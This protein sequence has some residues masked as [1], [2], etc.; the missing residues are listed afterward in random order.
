MEV[1]LNINIMKKQIITI[2]IIFICSPSLFATEDTLQINKKIENLEETQEKLE[3]ELKLF[4]EQLKQFDSKKTSLESSVNAIFQ[5]SNRL[6]S[7]IDSLSSLHA[8][9]KHSID[10]LDAQMEKQ[11][12]EL[13]G[14]ISETRETTTASIQEIDESLSKNTLYWII[15]I[16]FVGLLSLLAFIFLRKKTNAV[17]VSLTENIK[18]TRNE[19]EVEAVKLDNKLIQIMDTQLKMK[20]EENE[21]DHS[22]A[23]KVADEITRIEK[24]LSQMDE[25][26]RGLKQL[27]RA[28]KRI[29]DNFAA[30]GY[31]IVELLGKPFDE[32]MKLTANFLPD[33]TMSTGKR[34]ITRIIKPQ[35][36]YK[37]EMI[38]AAHV[39]VSKGI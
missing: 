18:N 25:G 21:E 4:D 9:N 5:R 20:G 8:E 1:N 26:I 19:L 10:A 14:Q 27:D 17:K 23:L 38:Q 34:I 36:N 29:K 6:Q 33:E 12:N 31:E 37:G 30:N 24:N 11:K 2:V 32:G 15:A 39:E 7:K 28:V 13:T 3:N 22:F 35:V 16:L